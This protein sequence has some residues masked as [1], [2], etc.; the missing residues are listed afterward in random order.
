[1]IAY[2]KKC[3]SVIKKRLE[4]KLKND[5]MESM[6]DQEESFNGQYS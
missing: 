4:Y 5:R 2:Y 6:E 3:D 1:M